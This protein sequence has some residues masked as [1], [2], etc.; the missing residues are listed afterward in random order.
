MPK[1]LTDAGTT[2][3][4]TTHADARTLVFDALGRM[5]QGGDGGLYFR[6]N[7]AGV[8]V[9][10]GL[11]NPSLSLREP[12]AVAYDS[13]SRRLVMS[14]QDTGSAYQSAP[15]N[16]TYRVVG[17]GGDGVNAA[18]ND[19]TLRGQGRSVIYMTSQNLAPLTRLL[20]DANGTVLDTDLSSA[21]ARA[22]TT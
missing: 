11:N 21:R 22:R 7:P 20:V 19:T 4:S 6:T 14:A 16:S 9:W 5:I 13:I 10:R 8:G 18:V 2:D 15:G 12:Y 3:G 17:G 1:R